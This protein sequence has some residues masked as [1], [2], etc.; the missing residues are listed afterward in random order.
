MVR[1]NN[2]VAGA[3]GT[4]GSALHG[5]QEA[6]NKGSRIRNKFAKHSLSHQLSL[7]G[8]FLKLPQPSV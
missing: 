3:G 8:Q 6:E 7:K 4:G 5:R 1:W 2:M